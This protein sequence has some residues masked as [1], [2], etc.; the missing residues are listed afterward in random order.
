[1]L[2]KQIPESKNIFEKYLVK[3]SGT[4]QHKSVSINE[5]RDAFFTFKLNKNPGYDE[6]SFNVVKNYFRELCEALKYVFNLSTET[7]LLP[8]KLKIAR[9]APVY[10]A[11]D[12]FDLTN[13]RP[14]SVLPCFSK[15]LERIMYDRLFSY[16]S[17]EKILYSKQFDIQSGHSTEHAILQL[18]NQIHE[19]FENSLYTLGVFI[20]LSKAFDTV[21]HSIILKTLEIYGILGKNP[22]WLKSYLINKKQYIQIDGKNKTDFSSVTC[23]VPEGS[24]LGPNASNILDRIM[25]T[26]DTNLFFS[27][28]NIPILLATVNSE[29]SKISL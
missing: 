24:I 11:G 5:L 28:C 22:E 19:S 2:A 8:D 16:S 18:V 20:D 6:I 21:N 1:M 29:L 4:M 25:F 13:Y 7:G 26:A 9:V 27:D 23:G 3:T 15:I 17:Q 14:I 10:K 12:T